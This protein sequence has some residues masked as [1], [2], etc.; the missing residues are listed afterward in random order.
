MRLLPEAALD[1]WASLEKQHEQQN[2]HI[3]SVG[4]AVQHEGNVKMNTYRRA[5]LCSPTLRS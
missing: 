4:T 1:V 2:Q 5:Y 3:E